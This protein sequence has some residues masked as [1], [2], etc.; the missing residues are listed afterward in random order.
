MLLTACSGGGSSSPSAGPTAS[1]ASVRAAGTVSVTH[2]QDSNWAGYVLASSGTT[3]TSFSSVSGSGDTVTLSISDLTRHT[4]VSKQLTM[5]SPTVSSAEWT[6]E[7]PPSVVRKFF[8][9]IPN[10]G[11]RIA[12]TWVGHF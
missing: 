4:T 6:A 1:W 9:L 7:E 8:L 12:R 3:T 2:Q 11:W 10:D 5:S